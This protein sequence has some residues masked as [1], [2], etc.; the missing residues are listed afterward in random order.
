MGADA[1]VERAVGH[2]AAIA[3]AMQ[4]APVRVR[5]RVTWQAVL[6]WKPHKQKAKGEE[7]HLRLSPCCQKGTVKG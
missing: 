1:A 6:G 3:T 5:V 2:A 4:S 7:R